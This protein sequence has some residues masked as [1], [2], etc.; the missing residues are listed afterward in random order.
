MKCILYDFRRAVTGRWF[1]LALLATTAALYMSIGRDS[2]FLISY[3]QDFDMYEDSFWLD[4]AGLVQ[5]AMQGEFSVM[6]LPALSA[7][8]FAAQALQEIRSGAI[9]PAVFRA[10]RRSWMAGKLSAC[11]IS[12]AWLQ[13]ASALA[14]LLVL[15]GMM[16]AAVGKP[17]PPGDMAALWPLL[18]RRMLCGGIWAGVGCLVA[19]LTETASAAYL[20]PLCLCY[21]MVMIG[22]RFFPDAALLNPTNWLTGAL[23][24]L[25]L[26][27]AALTI[28]LGWTLQRKVNAY[29]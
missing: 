22:T 6:T 7:L 24:P 20:A 15:H 12:G 14:L 23:W 28:A 5:S 29:V 10:G 13:M 17:F 19:L 4:A 1:V 16:L 9:R 21:A 27:L 18:L 11:L 2:Y 3:L 26:M 8:P 25:G